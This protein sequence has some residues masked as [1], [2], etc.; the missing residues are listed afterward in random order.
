MGRGDGPLPFQVGDGPGDLEDPVVG[1]GGEAQ[2]LHGHL[3]QA[4]GLGGRGAVLLDESGRHV[5]VGVDAGFM[6]TPRLDLPGRYD[7]GPQLDGALARFRGRQVPERHR[8]HLDLD[9]DPVQERPGDPG[10]VG[11]DLVG[12][13]GAGPFGVAQEAAGAGVHGRHQHEP[14]RVGQRGGRPGDGDLAFFQGL[15]QDLQGG[16]A[17]LRQ[18]V[19]EEHPV[20]GQ[21]HLPGPG[22]GA[23]ADEP[24]VRDGVVGRPEG[25]PGHQ[26]LAGFQA[27]HDAVD[28]GG[29]QGLFETPGRQ[30]R[31]QA[32]GQH[33]LAGAGRAHHQDVVAAG[34]G[35]EQGPLHRLLPLDVPEILVIGRGRAPAAPAVPG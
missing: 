34:G 22:D 13:A 7:P 29:L 16:A 27:P 5:G 25:A 2:A 32:P 3:Q 1:P 19:Q 33:G 12:G 10:T 21:A 14:G 20:V 9:V 31:A 11:V 23:A 28:L 8:R 6:E 35:D 26:G 24:G 4:L 17:E 15:A 18:F 30:H